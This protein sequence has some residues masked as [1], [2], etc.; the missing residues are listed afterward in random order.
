MTP[1]IGA[2]PWGVKRTSSVEP[3]LLEEFSRRR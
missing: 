3:V 1:W 2:S